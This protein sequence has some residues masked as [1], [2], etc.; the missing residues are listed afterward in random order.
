[1]DGQEHPVDSTT[2]EICVVMTDGQQHRYARTDGVQ[3]LPDGGSAVV[4]DWAGRY[5][6][7]K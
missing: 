4:F 3:R 2:D 7:P 6:G 1:M 5:Y